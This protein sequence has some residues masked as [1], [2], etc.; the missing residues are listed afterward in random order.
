MTD[1][2]AEDG[3]AVR[4]VPFISRVRLKNYKSIAECDVSLESLTVLVGPNG[5][6]KSNFLDALAF[7][8]RALTTT[9]AE[10]IGERG[11][12]REILQRVPE[13]T[14][15]FAIGIEA[16]VS[17]GSLPEQKLNASY[18]FEIGPSARGDHSSFEV[19]HEECIL[20][21]D[22]L[23]VA[24]FHVQRGE[25][26][27]DWF[28]IVGD[29]VFE[30]DRLVLPLAG[31]QMRYAQ[32]YAELSRM[33]FYNFNMK[34]L[35]DL[36][37]SD[38][39]AS[40]GQGGEHLGDVL[41][42][43][44]ADRGNYK[45]RIDAYIRAVVPDATAI[46]SSPAA[47]YTTVALRTSVGGEEF[48]FGPLS[49]SDGT[50]RAAAVLAALF[51]P[52]ALDGRIALV[53]IEEPEIALHPAAAAVLFD[54]LT[55]ASEYVQVLAT[56]QSSDLLDRDDLD[57]SIIRPV[58]MRDGLT[59]IGEVDDASREIAEKKLYTLGELMRGNQLTPKP[60]S[61]DALIP[62]EA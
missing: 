8:A 29:A 27:I 44:E 58:E 10:A 5:S 14:D 13:R 30:P 59:I 52:E 46:E 61:P 45:S 43:L 20:S 9:P 38:E 32:L 4:P 18:G 60:A 51:Q 50:I 54:A 37:P 19:V 3:A 49:I 53:G 34:T 36:Y 42:A 11:G 16:T 23:M 28:G 17:R 2:P 1:S 26:N 41:A 24:E 12:L 33:R 48:E 22:G 57:P 39:Q 6:G 31:A 15:T 62:E 47:G 55:E 25:G 21:R 7:L 56:S 35:R 40:L